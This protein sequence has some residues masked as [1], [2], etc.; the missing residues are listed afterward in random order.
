SISGEYIVGEKLIA[1]GHEVGELRATNGNV[2]IAL[3]KLEALPFE[4]VIN[5][6][7]VRVS[8]SSWMQLPE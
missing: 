3:L 2:G 7:S 1:N 5:G 4:I 6:H 8:K